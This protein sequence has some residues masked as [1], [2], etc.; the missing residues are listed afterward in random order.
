MILN[1]LSLP[2]ES[3]VLGAGKG[4]LAAC[5]ASLEW[6]SDGLEALS[7][8]SGC[9]CGEHVA[10]WCLRFCVGYSGNMRRDA[11]ELSYVAADLVVELGNEDLV[12]EA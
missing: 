2:V 12:V 8:S 4:A 11:V 6:G 7:R 9:S 10:V 5:E 1:S 3:V